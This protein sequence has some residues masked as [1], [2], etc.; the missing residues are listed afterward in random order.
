MDVFGVLVRSV[1]D[2]TTGDVVVE[3]VGSSALLVDGP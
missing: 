1:V 2:D 3:P